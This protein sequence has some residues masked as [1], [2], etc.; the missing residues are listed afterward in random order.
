MSTIHSSLSSGLMTYDFST[1]SV[2]FRGIFTW[3]E[4]DEDDLYFSVMLVRK[5]NIAKEETK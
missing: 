4:L 3:I 1:V 5:T 2:V